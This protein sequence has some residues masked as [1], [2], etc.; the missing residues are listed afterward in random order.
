MHRLTRRN[1]LANLA[2]S[3]VFL[4]PAILNAQVPA[5]NWGE[6]PTDAPIGADRI[7]TMPPGPVEIDISDLQPGDVAVVARPTDNP[8]YTNTGMTQYI[9]VL[10]RTDE[11]IAFGAAHDRPGDVQDARFMVVDLMCPHRGKAIGLTGNPEAPFACTDQ[12]SRHSSVFDASGYGIGGASA[13]EYMSFPAYS[14]KSDSGGAI[15][16]SLI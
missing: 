10:R 13:E 7:L 9:A 1:V 6:I 15:V 5:P 16:V 14:I 11:Q 2:G 12:G 4:C 8:E 3:T